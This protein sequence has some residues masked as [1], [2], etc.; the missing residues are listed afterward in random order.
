MNSRSATSPL[1]RPS[2]S[3]ASSGGSGT[4]I[5]PE[6]GSKNENRSPSR[7][8]SGSNSGVHTRSAFTRSW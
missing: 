8:T 4:A 5:A 7:Y 2:G 1:S 3:S 6:A